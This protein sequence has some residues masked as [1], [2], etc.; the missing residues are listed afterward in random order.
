MKNFYSMS[1][2][3]SQRK[4]LVTVCIPGCKSPRHIKGIM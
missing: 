1:P 2:R 4:Q 3:A